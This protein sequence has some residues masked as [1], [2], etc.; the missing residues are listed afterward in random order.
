MQ[1]PKVLCIDLRWIDSSGVGVYIKGIMP[2]IVDR[3]TDV[4]VVGLGNASR[5]REFS[6]SSSQN[7]R[8]IDCRAERYSLAEQIELPFAI[9]SDTDLF[10]SPYY[11]IPL[12][13]RGRLAVT[14]HDMSHLVVAEIVGSL[15]KRVY[16]RTMFRALRKRAAFIFTVSNFSKSELI[17]L[18]T[19]PR[20]DNIIPTHLGITEDWHGA[21]DLPVVRSRPYFVCVGNVKPYKNLGRLVEAFLRIQHKIAHD[22]VIIGQSEGLITGESHEFFERVRA[23]GDRIQLTGYVSRMQLLS[24]VGHADALVMPSLYEG[25][26][27]P[28][29]EA[30]A[31]GVPTVVA[32]VASLPEVCGD[33]A[34]YFEPL[35]VGDIADKLTLIAFDTQLRARLRKEGLERSMLFSWDA[36][37]RTTAET[38]RACL[39]SSS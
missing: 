2:G 13:Y 37:S 35:Q 12:L 19:G 17:R 30:M 22:L 32:R 33:S 20:E 4:N 27:L 16:A 38:L 28:P 21:A 10:F 25:F 9:P 34:L 14:V 8:L 1:S 11:T 31:A 26:G 23:A 6:W 15:K 5:L 36:C 3:L 29:L 39:Y 18:T 24:L 7:V